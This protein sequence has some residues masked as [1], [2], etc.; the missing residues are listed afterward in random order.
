[1]GF[2]PIT[3]FL[4]LEFATVA[5]TAGTTP[6]PAIEDM[7][8]RITSPL[9]LVTAGPPEKDAR[10]VYDRGAGDRPLDPWT[11]PTSATQTPS[12]GRARDEDRVT[13]FLDATRTGP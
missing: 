11:C 3:P 2:T 9:L 10:E 7:M 5:V 1:M 12:P 13:E 6:G 4:A 8:K